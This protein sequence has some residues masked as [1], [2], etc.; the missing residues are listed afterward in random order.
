MTTGKALNGKPYAG[1]PHVRF[2]EGEVASAA[3]PMRGSLLYRKSVCIFIVAV[4]MA[5]VAGSVEEIVSRR[6]PAPQPYAY[7]SGGRAEAAPKAAVDP[8]AGYVWDSPKATDKLQVYVMTPARATDKSNSG[9]F[10]GLDTASR[11]RCD[12]RVN[13]TGTILVDFGVELPAWLEFDS[14]DLSGDVTCAVSEYNEVYSARGNKTRVPR[15]VGE[16]TYRLVLN[17]ELYEGLR[18]AFINVRK[19]D[20][21][22]TI[23]AIRAV[24][25]VMPVNYTGAFSSDNPTLDRIWY[26]AA[27]DVRANIREDCF[28]AIL[29]DRGDRHSWTGDSYPAQAASLVAFS[30][31]DAV[32]KNLRYTE[33]HPNCIESFELYWIESLIDYYMYSGDA[34]G[35][36][37]LIPQALKRLDHALDIVYDPRRLGFFGWDER[38]GIGFDHPDCPENRRGYQMLTVGALKHFAGVLDRL[39]ERAAAEKYRT[40]AKDVTARLLSNGKYLSRLGMHSSADAI[41]A[42]LLPDLSR[43]Y[44]RDL[45]DRLQRLS[46]SPFNQHMLLKAMSKAG[47][48]G[49][50]FASVVDLWGGQ[51]EYGAT[52][53]LEVY[54][55]S[56]NKIV[57]EL[58]P[59]PFTQC[60]HTSLAHPWGAGVLQWLT[61]EMLGIKPVEPGFSRFV[62]KPHFEG[63]ATRVSG[64][65]S[66]PHGR[67]EASFD[68]KSGRHSV[69]VPQGTVATVALPK[70][71]M[72]V[73]RF[74]L[75]VNG[76]N[77]AQPA[78]ARE[79]GDFV[80]LDELPA[81]RYDFTVEYEGEPRKARQEEYVYAA[82]FI[83]E[84]RETHGEW[85]RKYGRDGYF[86]VCG[87]KNKEDLAVLPDYVESVTFDTAGHDVKRHRT[88]GIRPLDPRA[89]LP[90]NRDG[91]GPRVFECY[92]SA[93]LQMCPVDIR[94]K[95][96][97]KFRVALYVADCRQVGPFPR[98]LNFDAYDLETL[99]RVAPSVRVDDFAGGVYLIFEYDRS[100]RIRGNNI[101]G[102][103]AVINAV[104]FD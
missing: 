57:G 40:A 96:P 41:N 99:N 82:K 54:R 35:T 15:K 4:S 10:A 64:H 46:Y 26:V 62:V 63:R 66:T 55:P 93:G 13:G 25:Q 50:A 74:V 31:Y 2:D 27:W 6:S 70:E 71:G 88:T 12:I 68:L 34:E 83:G 3:T 90:V 52:C 100:L 58:G 102:D 104:F 91:S 51:V 9:S 95:S 72:R 97:R 61:E 44:H 11:E 69:V 86:I 103:N 43:L 42:D 21:P 30:N 76:G 29:M 80:C 5:A 81:G 14:P 47:H 98:E 37:S 17:K 45:S 19:F 85:Y 59:L 75:K 48:Y 32:L 1:N 8:M 22:F 101:R 78:P 84:D 53:F 89:T 92:H 33:C 20:K 65:V 36:R 77:R 39:G 23:T 7:V 18:F 38:T 60:G 24:T 56:W 87:G 73:K 94:L 49:D 67:V 28:G 79:D 16:K